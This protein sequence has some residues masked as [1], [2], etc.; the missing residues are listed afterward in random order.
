MKITKELIT[1]I[2]ANN[3]VEN[4]VY[5]IEEIININNNIQSLIKEKNNQTGIYRTIIYKIDDKIN[6]IREK[7]NHYLINEQCQI[8]Y[9][10]IDYFC[11]GYDG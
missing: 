7:C 10:V 4:L 8:C 1:A 3:P 6:R 11:R 9:K 5:K 2:L